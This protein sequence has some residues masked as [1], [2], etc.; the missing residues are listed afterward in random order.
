MYVLIG[1]GTSGGSR[2]FS[3]SSEA[4]GVGSATGSDVVG[5]VDVGSDGVV[6]VAGDDVAVAGDGAVAVSVCSI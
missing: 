4:A 2:E 1:W 3:Q 5:E 6:V